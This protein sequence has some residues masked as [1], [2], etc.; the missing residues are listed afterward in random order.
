MITVGLAKWLAEAKE[1]LLYDSIL[2]IIQRAEQGSAHDQSRI[3]WRYAEGNG[4]PVDYPRAY[5]WL[6]LASAQERNYIQG[7]DFIVRQMRPTQIEEGQRLIREWLVKHP[8]PVP[9]DYQTLLKLAQGEEW[10]PFSDGREKKGIHI[11]NIN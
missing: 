7:L 2:S 9:K 3:G 5:M 11:F 4:V 8:R 1:F 6:S 10:S